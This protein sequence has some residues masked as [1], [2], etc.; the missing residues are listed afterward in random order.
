VA[1]FVLVHGAWSW[2]RFAEP[3]PRKSGHDVYPVTLTGLGEPSHLATPEDD[4]DTHIQD[5]VNVL[6]Y[7]DPGD[8]IMTGH[9]YD[10]NVITGVSDLRP[11]RLRQLLCQEQRALK[12]KSDPRWTY[13]ELK[14]G[15]NLHGTAPEET[16][17]ILNELAVR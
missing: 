10:G 1:T 15:Y 2:T 7:E 17:R 12:V 9:S 11:E 13:H 3:L 14:T 16:V 5:V 6:F 8:A 4:L